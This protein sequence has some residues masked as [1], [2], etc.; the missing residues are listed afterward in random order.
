MRYATYRD[1]VDGRN[2]RRLAVFVSRFLG[3]SAIAL[4]LALSFIT[5]SAAAPDDTEIVGV[6]WQGASG[7]TESVADIMARQRQID[8]TSPAHGPPR[9]IREEFELERHPA[10]NPDAPAVSQWPPSR[11]P[12]TPIESRA[13][14]PIGVNFL[15]TQI[16]EGPG[17]P[18]G[19][20][21][22][23]ARHERAL[24]EAQKNRDDAMQSVAAIQKRLN[25][26]S[27]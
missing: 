10:P 24:A 22:Q 23:V 1:S 2:L 26:S 25:P 16:N 13:P 21:G 27:R 12:A 5:T 19:K 17:S 3:T 14:Q 6:P 11:E 8:S 15:A 9:P 18:E 20:A 7:I 4:L